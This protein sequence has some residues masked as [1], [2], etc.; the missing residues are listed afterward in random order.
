[1]HPVGPS[2]EKGGSYTTT[3]VTW[4]FLHPDLEEVFNFDWDA[5]NPESGDI[6][7]NMELLPKIESRGLPYCSSDGHERLF[8]LE[9]PHHL[10]AEK[11]VLDA[12]VPCMLCGNFQK[13][14]AMR[15]HVGAHI[16]PSCRGIK[17]DLKQSVGIEACGFCG[18]DGCQIQLTVV[19]KKGKATIASSCKYHH[20]TM[21]YK[22]A[23]KS[24]RTT[25]CSNVPIHCLLCPLSASGQLH[26]I[27]KYNALYQLITEHTDENGKLP[28]IP[29]A[30]MVDMHVS[31]EEELLMEVERATTEVWREEHD[32]PGSDAVEEIEEAVTV[33]LKCGRGA[34][35]VVNEPISKSA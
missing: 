32:I 30:M 20:S 22:A 7:G 16:L 14:A 15:N 8:V 28:H 33:S 6:L 26:T 31:M 4:S 21:L 23:S 3:D 24:T 9:L 27:W 18:L 29:G 19:S 35:T 17:L 13:L 12:K 5:L 2:V 10:T 1:V 11:L 25:P 34:S